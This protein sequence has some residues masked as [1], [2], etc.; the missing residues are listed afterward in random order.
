MSF[1]KS[2]LRN[3]SGPF[4]HRLPHNIVSQQLAGTVDVLAERF[5]AEIHAGFLLVRQ[6]SGNSGPMVLVSVSRVTV[7]VWYFLSFLPAASFLDLVRTNDMEKP[8]ETPLG[9]QARKRIREVR[10][11][12]ALEVSYVTYAQKMMD[13]RRIGYAEGPEEGFKDTII[14]LKDILDPAAFS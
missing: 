9:Q 7:S 5:Q 11:D 8:Y 13:E 14:A 2:V 4:C 10:G 12:K 3:D 1:C 6:H